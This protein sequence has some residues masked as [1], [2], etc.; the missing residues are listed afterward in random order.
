MKLMKKSKFYELAEKEKNVLGK[1][2]KMN[3][4]R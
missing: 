3:K 2:V 4:C 1:S